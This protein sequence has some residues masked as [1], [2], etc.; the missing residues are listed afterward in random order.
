MDASGGRDLV[1]HDFEQLVDGGRDPS[2]YVPETTRVSRG[3]RDQRADDVVDMDEVPGLFT[4]SEDGDALT[5]RES[6]GEDSHDTALKAA[7]LSGPV[8]IGEARDGM[9]DASELDI[10]LG[11]ILVNGVVT[12]R[13]GHSILGR[14]LVVTVH[15]AATRDEHEPALHTDAGIDDV[16]GANHIDSKVFIRM[17]H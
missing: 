13:R 14:R 1:L 7:A 17:S 15:S 6:T 4:T 12:C 3:H 10:S 5:A 9:T 2:A 8:H 11:R 16:P